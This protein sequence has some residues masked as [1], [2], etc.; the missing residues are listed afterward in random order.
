MV[1][2]RTLFKPS[3][4]CSAIAAASSAGLI[5][6]IA[7]AQQAAGA[8]TGLLEEVV[9]TGIR[10]SLKDSLDVKRDATQIVDAV[11]A[12]DVGKFPD[13]NVAESL[14][15][16]TGVSIDR[17]GGEGQ[18]ITV[19]GL[20]PEFNTVLLNGR[21][22]ATDND[23]REFSFDVLSSD[24]IQRAEVYKTSTPN[25][26]SGGIGAVVNV[27]TARPFDRPGTHFT[28][29]GAAIYDDLRED[30]TPEFSGVGSWTNDD[31]TFGVLLGVSYQERNAQIEGVNVGGYLVRDGSLA[32]NAPESSTGLQPD[33]IGVLPEGTR[34]MQNLGFTL[35]EQDR[36]RL[37]VNG[38]FQFRPSDRTEITVDGL[39]SRFD[40]Q[41]LQTV[42]TGFF[43]PQFIDPV[44][45]GNGTVTDFS[46]PSL[47]FNN[48]NPA[49]ATD[50]WLSQDD[51]VMT[52]NNREAE[53]YLVGVNFKW[54]LTDAMTLTLDAST[55]NANRDDT[56]PFVV[57]GKLS[58][59][60][61]TI[62][63]RDNGIPSLT[64]WSELT[65]VSLQ[66]LHFVDVARDVVEDDINEAFATLDWNIDR[67][68]LKVV[69]AGVAY[70]ERE[71]VR[72]RFDTFS[73]TQG[74][75]I[76]CAYCGYTVTPN[77]TSFLNPFSFQ[78]FLSG[79]P[80]SS[81][82][83]DASL[84]FSFADVFRV[85]ND[86]ANIGAP[87]RAGRDSIS[88][89]ELLQ[90]IEAAGDSLFGFYTPDINSAA[91]FAVEEE[92]TSFFVN[93]EWEG[94]FG[95]MPWAATAGFRVARTEVV[96]TGVD[97]PVLQFRESVNDT[98]LDIIFGDATDVSVSNSYTDVLPS[99]NFRVDATD[100][101]V[102]RAS[103]S[104]TITRPTLDEL[105]VSNTF[106]GRS[107]APVS[108]GGNPTLEAFESDNFDASF[109]WYFDELGFF[110]VA[111]FHKEFDSFLESQ[112]LPIPRPIVFPANNPGNPTNVEVTRDVD[113]QDTRTRNGETGSITGFE[114]AVQ[115][116]FDTLP[117]PFDGFGAQANYT[118]VSSDIDRA[119]NSGA[120]DCD[121]N[122]LSPNSYNVSAFYEKYGIS[123]RL[124]Y[125]FREEFLF[126][127]FSD[128]S[129][130]REREDFGQLDFSAA[131]SINDSIQVY[132][133]GIN[134]T[135][136]DTRDF[137]RF[138]NRLLD[139]T[140]TGTRF[141]LG[142]RGV[143]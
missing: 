50:S 17:S 75:G 88:D 31:E 126:E 68:A 61:Q 51:N 102:L 2:R 104:Q 74:F 49:I 94:S 87:N 26:R 78:G 84:A 24:I 67:G 38:S 80:G 103:Y 14:Q 33:A 132:L 135:E 120:S 77:D 55:S 118:H 130:P 60:S 119:E 81:D 12:E 86:P 63:L 5:S 21:T 34:V 107:N 22:M 117:A 141:T 37:S 115:K 82:V 19:R 48:R 97:Q 20:G 53:T 45:D 23:G 59:T 99:F 15:R 123:L 3:L 98:Q 69:S 46:R 113:F 11:S 42:V 10:S 52:S 36:E 62:S 139:Y 57:V 121:Y 32:V 83:P 137:S 8:S 111:A 16:I 30:A 124:A 116:T 90:R 72:D 79:T 64:N 122:G 129:E 18:F 106:G 131:Y 101:I 140:R 85:L 110:G 133:E 13:M 76:F 28:A 143:F 25:L 4:L 125:N 70:S 105:G 47:D 73:A 109:E 136:E 27:V 96:S 58:E 114:V 41:S 1:Y 71:K 100:D 54:D 91:S 39:Y 127:C 108:G 92:V 138:S 66:R 44:I 134:I 9:V 6:E 142:V 56:N 7:S 93:T 95:D 112:T 40:I 65:N 128:A 35:D 29:S 89:E 43:N